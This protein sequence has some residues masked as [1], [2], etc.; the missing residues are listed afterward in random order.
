MIDDRGE[1]LFTEGDAVLR[2]AGTLVRCNRVADIPRSDRLT[3]AM[4]PFSQVRERGF[5]A[6]DDG[7]PILALVCDSV[8][9]ET[10]PAEGALPPVV[11]SGVEHV[12]SDEQ[13][14]ERVRQV[15]DREISRGEGS[16]VLLARRALFAIDSF[17]PEVGERLFWKLHAAERNA[18]R[19]FCFR[20]GGHHWIGASPERNVRV[21]EGTVR[22]NPICGTLPLTEPVTADDLRRFLSDPKEI[23]ELFQVLDE[24]LKMMASLCEEGGRVL[25]PYLKLMASVL[26]TEYELEGRTSLDPLEV[27]ERSMFAPTMIGS[28]LKNAARIVAKYETVPRGYYS[29]AIAFLNGPSGPAPD[30]LD[31][32]ITIRTLHVDPDGAG[33]VFSGASIVRDS[34]PEDEVREVNAKADAVL[35]LLS[36]GSDADRRGHVPPVDAPWVEPLLEERNAFLSPFWLSPQAGIVAGATIGNAV[37]VDFDD[38]FSQMLGHM[39]GRLGFAASVLNWED[40]HPGA[41]DGAD[42]VV[43]GPGPGD[44]TDHEVPKIAFARQMVQRLLATET[45]F[46]AICLS[47]QILCDLLGFRVVP[48]SPSLQGVQR[49]IDY[50]GRTEHVGLYN[51]FV[52][53]PT[54][55]APA[56]SS[57]EVCADP[58]MV[59][60]LRGETFES[61]QFHVESVL[62]TGGTRI[63]SEAVAR[64]RSAAAPSSSSGDLTGTR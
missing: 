14:A 34:V 10:A 26:H 47:H 43:A 11:V 35:T 23:H 53:S 6:I 38:D 18:Y 40:F 13:F 42:L 44:P 51:T 17:T 16:N 33:T 3:I 50:F 15:I 12:P 46:L 64:L 24:E 32:A 20:A 19:T 58:E 48:L 8:L 28:P 41:L 9:E 45:P 5:E 25:G 22:M 55:A 29:A 57:L 2:A 60:A 56:A 52:G 31:S 21:R 1:C 49:R 27:F 63:L 7:A 62:T 4:V 36:R 39:L 59:Y 54:D 30:E 37:I 61:F